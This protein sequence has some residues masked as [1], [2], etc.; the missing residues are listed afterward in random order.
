MKQIADK[1]NANIKAGKVKYSDNSFN[2]DLQVNKKEVS[3]KSFEQAEFE[4]YCMLFGF[5]PTDYNKQFNMNGK[6]FT[7]KGLNLKAHKMPVKAVCSDGKAYK[8][9]EDTVKRLLLV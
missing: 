5:K 3:G 7:I 2:L 1:Y 4:K 8:F 6:T 9:G